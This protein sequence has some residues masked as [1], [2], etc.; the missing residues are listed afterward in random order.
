MCGPTLKEKLLRTVA[1]AYFIS[2]GLY[3]FLLTII[4]TVT[5]QHE[6]GVLLQFSKLRDRAFSRFWIAYGEFMSEGM[7]DEAVA[8]IGSVRGTVLDIGPGSGDQTVH[9]TPANLTRVYGAEPAGQLHDKL[10]AKV[11]GAGLEG[12]YTVLHAGA[13]PESLIPA[14]ADAGLFKN[15]SEGIFDEICCIRVLCGVPRPEETVRGLYKLLKPGG[16]MIVHEHVVNPWQEAGGNFGSRVL[17]TVYA[18]AGWNVFLGC[19]ID[20]D[21]KEILLNAGGKDGW[22]RVELKS[23]QTWSVL[24]YCTGYLVKRG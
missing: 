21:T 10:R 11:K 13:Q 24:P 9:F 4:D 15:G 6:P 20:R 19:S 18:W 3:Q 1:P 8:L 14:L 12:K 5:V 22:S 2:L 7:A 23:L 17:Q 16:R